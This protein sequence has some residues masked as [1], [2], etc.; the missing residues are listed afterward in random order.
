VKVGPCH[1]YVILHA[2]GAYAP[3]SRAEREGLDLIAAWARQ[4]DESDLVLS[5][6]YQREELP[7]WWEHQQRGRSGRELAEEIVLRTLAGYR[8]AVDRAGPQGQVAVALGHGETNRW[9]AWVDLAPSGALRVSLPMLERLAAVVLD[10]QPLEL[11]YEERAF[12]ALR[13]ILRG[14]GPRPRVSRIDLL[15][16][17]VGTEVGGQHLLDWLHA[18]WGIPV[19]GLRGVVVFDGP[20]RAGMVPPGS[21]SATV[22][23]PA[24]T[25][26][27]QRA[28][29]Y[30][31][32]FYHSTLPDRLWQSSRGRRPSRLHAGNRD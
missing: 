8:R 5:G 3:F 9:F 28:N 2:T 10:H 13:H 25:S 11:S 20:Y 32:P 17:S 22:L 29:G 18:L 26:P 30:G 7:P 16:C 6:H 12:L 19:R 24:R 27:R 4:V 21:A 14:D 15:T 1:T 31:A 23:A